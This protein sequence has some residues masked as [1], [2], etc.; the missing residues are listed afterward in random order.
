MARGWVLYGDRLCDIHRN[1]ISLYILIFNGKCILA[2][3]FL[4]IR[5]KYMQMTLSNFI[6]TH[7]Y[8]KK[9]NLKA[10]PSLYTR[11]SSRLV[12]FLW[13]Y[14][15]QNGSY[16]GNLWQVFEVYNNTYPPYKPPMAS[17]FEFRFY[18]RSNVLGTLCVGYLW[19]FYRYTGHLEV[20]QLK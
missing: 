13:I 9:K 10:N 1:I 6:S 2:L 7:I 18:W 19:N 11:W 3:S 5:K 20:N 16:L 12:P 14:A 8:W 17:L 15:H 4:N